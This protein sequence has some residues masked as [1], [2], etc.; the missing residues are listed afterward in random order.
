MKWTKK[1]WEEAIDKGSIKESHEI[2]DFGLSLQAK[3][4]FEAANVLKANNINNSPY[5]MM[6]SLSIECYLKSIRTTTY[7][8][9]SRGIGVMHEKGHDLSQLF[10]TLSEKYPQDASYLSKQYQIKFGGN[11]SQDL[12]QNANV[13]TCQR[14]PYKIDNSIPMNE[15]VWN[16]PPNNVHYW[17]QEKRDNSLFVN[18]TAL[19]N[20][21][22]FFHKELA[23]RF[24]E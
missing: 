13:F 20:V 8:R 1:K 3:H 24:P 21:A 5:Y 10:T 14:Y 15:Y 16:C 11:L 2:V 9:G 23:P 18:L 4:Y 7:W 6:L 17:G 19:E 22:S 12:A